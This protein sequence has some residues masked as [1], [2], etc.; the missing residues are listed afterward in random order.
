LRSAVARNHQLK[1]NVRHPVYES[2]YGLTQ[3]V[4]RLHD[5]QQASILG[6]KSVVLSVVEF[7]LSRHPNIS[8]VRRIK[9]SC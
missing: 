9:S 5:P 3:I 6:T 4:T 1:V 2:L 7:R 8:L